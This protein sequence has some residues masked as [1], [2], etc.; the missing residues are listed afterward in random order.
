[1]LETAIKAAK[2]AGGYLQ[3]AFEK[4][5]SLS[6]RYKDKY[7]IVTEADVRSEEIILEELK[8]AFPDHAFFAEESGQDGVKSDFLW[9]IDPLDGTSNFSRKIPYFC[10]SIGLIYKGNPVLGVIYQPIFDELFAAEKGN[11]AEYNSVKINTGKE[12]N[13]DKA[14]VVLSRGTRENTKEKFWNTL[15]KTDRAIKS[16]RVEGAVA[17]DCAY[18]A[19]GRFDAVISYG[20]TLYDYTA[21]CVIAREAGA[22]VTDFQGNDWV[23]KSDE[24]LV[25][26][27]PL[28]AQLIN[29]LKN[30]NS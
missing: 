12:K 15:A 22:Q 1:M 8:K 24:V 25:A 30:K 13:L 16:V 20:C 14:I 21:G 5:H 3:E 26:N 18:A 27:P 9:V 10:I 11:G 7:S 29:L 6:Y 17:L 4:T 2:K 28:H 23:P 19:C